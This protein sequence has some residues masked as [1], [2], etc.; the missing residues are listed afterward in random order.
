MK[1]VVITGAN[2]GIGLAIVEKFLEKGFCVIATTRTF[3]RINFEA[4]NLFWIELDLSNSE[5]IAQATHIICD[6]YKGID[7]LINNARVGLDLKTTE[8]NLDWIRSTF[9]VNV[10]G[11]IDFTERLKDNIVTGGTIFNISSIM[12]KL[13]RETQVTNATAYRMSKSALNMYT[14]VLAARLVER[15]IR[16]VSVHPGWVKTQMGGVEA[17]ILPAQAAE[18][19]IKLYNQP[20]ET[21]SFWSAETLDKLNW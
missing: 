14:R 8:P 2:R 7:L 16:V 6:K 11:L 12:G 18:N 4:E 5:S 19:I 3:D 17:P 20:I 1:K 10:F 15:N 13:E 21:N 9:E